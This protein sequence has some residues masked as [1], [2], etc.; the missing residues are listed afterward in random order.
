MVQPVQKCCKFLC[1]KVQVIG[2]YIYPEKTFDCQDFHDCRPDYITGQ[3]VLA[4]FSIW[5]LCY[6]FGLTDLERFSYYIIGRCLIFF[7]VTA[8]FVNLLQVIWR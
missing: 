5:D 2:D 7:A 6:F 3:L 4:K 1:T 8:G